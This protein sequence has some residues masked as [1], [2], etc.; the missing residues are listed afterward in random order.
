[1]REQENGGTSWKRIRH[2]IFKRATENPLD[3]AQA[4]LPARHHYGV[5]AISG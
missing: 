2:S 4:I 3:D 1:M 5:T